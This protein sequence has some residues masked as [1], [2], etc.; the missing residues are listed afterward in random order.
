MAAVGLT[1]TSREP[2]TI[3]ST[4]KALDSGVR[5]EKSVIAYLERFSCVRYF[6]KAR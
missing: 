6:E 4:Y 5:S 2:A 1:S 3:A